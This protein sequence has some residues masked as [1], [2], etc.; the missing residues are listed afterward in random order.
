MNFSGYQVYTV[1]FEAHGTGSPTE[2]VMLADSLNIHLW[3]AKNGNPNW[4][5]TAQKIANDKKVPV[6]FFIAD[7][8]Y[9]GSVSVPGFGTFNHILDYVSP[10][11]V[12]RVNFKDSTSWQ[13]LQKTTLTQLMRNNSGLILQISNNEPMARIILDESI[14]KGGYLG[15]STVHFGQN[16]SFAQPYYHQYRYQLPFVTLQDA[17]GTESWWWAN[18]LASHRTLF[19]A[20]KPTYDEMVTALKNSW[21]VAIRHDSISEYKTRM[22]GGT[23]DARQFIQKEEKNWKWW[24]TANSDEN[25][26]WAAITVIRPTDSLEV[27]YPE[28]GVNIRIRP[29]LNG[30]RQM[31]KDPQVSLIQL[32]IDQVVVEPKMIKH[33]DK[34]GALT[35]TF[36]LHAMPNIAQGEHLIQATLKSLRDN[37]TRTIT[38][39]FT[40]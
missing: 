35:D 20:K 24:K 34:K 15:I 36:Y 21:A 25:R 7:E 29:W 1:Q 3:G 27:S 19:I 31:I 22:L 32:K 11:S 23:T 40:Y 14:K 5:K 18:E 16:F 37:R 38:Q 33:T 8:P 30:V 2:A 39:K 10:V 6:T 4:V 28:K 12:G 13:D 26:P 17:H 9:S